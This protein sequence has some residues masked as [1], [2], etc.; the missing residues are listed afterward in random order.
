ME[1]ISLTKKQNQEV[2]NQE[3]F[4]YEIIIITP[5]IE[6]YPDLEIYGTLLCF[7]YNVIK[8]RNK[9]IHD[10][11]EIEKAFT[12]NENSLLVININNDT[13]FE[14]NLNTISEY[15]GGNFLYKPKNSNNIYICRYNIDIGGCI[16]EFN[17]N[18]INKE[19]PK[20]A[21]VKVVDFVS[22]MDNIK[23]RNIMGRWGLSKS[24]DKIFGKK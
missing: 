6:K 18:F 19:I 17:P 11:G 4:K 20:L 21:V 2:L 16:G 10:Y 7:N 8:A 22:L 15:C 3:L 13:K 12:I 9:Y 24:R 14:Q 23:T 5:D 1:T